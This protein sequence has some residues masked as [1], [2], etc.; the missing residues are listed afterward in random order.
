[1]DCWTI[2]LALQ[3]V[4]SLLAR[5]GDEARKEA[6]G[7]SDGGSARVPLELSARVLSFT[8]GMRVTLGSPWAL[9]AAFT[10]QSA[11]HRLPRALCAARAD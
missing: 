2:R 1:P 6:I 3:A 7:Q 11:A 10:E 4:L 8:V 5:P 9:T